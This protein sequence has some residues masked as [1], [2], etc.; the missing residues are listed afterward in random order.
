MSRPGA[1]DVRGTR[2]Y[3]LASAD[4]D[5]PEWEG[6]P[7]RSILVCTHPRSGSTLLGEAMAFAGG[8]GAPLEYYHRGFRPAFERRWRTQGI[9][10]LRATLHRRR[11]A[12]SGVF[13]AKLF[14]VDIQ[15]MALEVDP[16]R[17]KVL[18]GAPAEHL[19]DETYREAWTA[20]EPLFPNPVF[21]H[22]TR[23]DRLRQAV[24]Q[25]VAQQTGLWRSIPELGADLG[26]Q[27]ATYDR[28]RIGYLMG[29]ADFVNTHWTRF[30]AAIGA[31]PYKIT[32][33]DLS[34]DYS[35]TVTGLL[36]R[37]GSPGAVAPARLRRQSDR[38]TESFVLRFLRD[39]AAEIRK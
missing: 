4:H 6:A 10:E 22:L 2:P 21:V 31:T 20:L 3:D 28:E 25:I 35:G 36:R 30:F 8:L 26:E 19:T 11:T 14:W 24:S 29:L 1:D 18:W 34:R 27:E 12:P 15:E 7:L 13:S 37:L 17:F 39:A 16:E 32:Y 33:E 9:D 38:I 5:L 23:R